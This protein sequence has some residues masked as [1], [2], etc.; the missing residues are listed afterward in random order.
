MKTTPALII[1]AILLLGLLAIV[2]SAQAAPPGPQCVLP[3]DGPLPDGIGSIPSCK[4]VDRYDAGGTIHTTV[5]SDCRTQIDIKSYDCVWNCGWNTVVSSPYLT[6]RQYGQ[7]SGEA[8]MAAVAPPTP[9]C[10]ETSVATSDFLAYLGPHAGVALQSDCT[11]DAWEAGLVCPKVAPDPG[12]VDRDVGPV[13]VQADTCIPPLDCTCDPMPQLLDLSGI[14]TSSAAI[15]PFPTCIRECTPQIVPDG[16]DLRA[17]TPASTPVGW[18]NPQDRIWGADCTVDVEPAYEC[19]GGWGFDRHVTAAFIDVTARVCT[20][21]PFP[22]AIV[23]AILDA[24]R[25][26]Q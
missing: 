24:I 7:T 10:R 17:L 18:L 19:V 20:G 3:C 11:V 21:G 16:C 9:T 8:T 12:S 23:Q 22:P 5:S 14:S 2:P 15:D 6:I 13:G 4:P 26:E 1:S 25:L